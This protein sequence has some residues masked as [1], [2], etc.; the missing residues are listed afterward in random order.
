MN[1]SSSS[2]LR[3]ILLAF[4][5]VAV[6]YFGQEFLIPLAIGGILS[7]LFLPFCGWLVRKKLPNGF[8]V[9]VCLLVLVSFIALLIS[10][11]GWKI[12]DLI[13]DI[14]LLKQE[15]TDCY[16]LIQEYIFQKSG[17]SVA[18]QTQI[19]NDEKPSFSNL[20]QITFGSIFSIL[21]NTIMALI[22]F[23]FLLY[24]RVHLRNFFIKLVPPSQKVEMEQT[25]GSVARVA[26]QYLLGLSKMIVCLWIM[27]AIGF[28]IIG[29][30]DVLFFAILCGFLELIPYLGNI[31]GA[32]LTVLFSVMHGADASMAVGILVVYV[33]VQS[34]QA[35]VLGPL[36][37]GPQVQINPLFSIIALVI[38][39]ILWGIPGVILAIPLLGMFKII[40][41]HVESLHSIGFLIGE[42]EVPPGR[43]AKQKA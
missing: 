33:L 37:L 3:K 8:A 4:L 21:T 40:C 5:L 18:Q 6:L 35:W 10:L 25:L 39:Q 9:V 38:G 12:A 24:S 23:V 19:L 11:L 22:Y 7:T 1:A 2:V 36:I 20:V 13:V 15:A 16:L 29:I 30:Q 28:S 43:E 41:D 14:D 17:I 34:I 32:F 26:Q 42:I 27:Y 31:T